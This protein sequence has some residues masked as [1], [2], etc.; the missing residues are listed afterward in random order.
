MNRARM[1]TIR[2]RDGSLAVAYPPGANLD[3]IRWAMRILGAEG[4][5]LAVNDEGLRSMSFREWR[6]RHPSGRH[7]Y[8]VHRTRTSVSCGARN[9]ELRT[10]RIPNRCVFASLTKPW[11]IFLAHVPTGFMAGVRVST[12]R[13]LFQMICWALNIHHLGEI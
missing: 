8:R 5:A 10:G 1:R 11:S 2:L 12:V 4:M 7:D 13:P 3:E 6:V 9:D